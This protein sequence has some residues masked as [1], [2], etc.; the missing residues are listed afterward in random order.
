MSHKIRDF[1]S[2]TGILRR[3]VSCPKL[4]FGRHSA[5][6]LLGEHTIHLVGWGLV[7]FSVHTDGEQVRTYAIFCLYP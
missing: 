1:P 5:R 6:T 3:L 2:T 7:L 4:V